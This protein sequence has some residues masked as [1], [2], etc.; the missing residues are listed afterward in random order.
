MRMIEPKVTGAFVDAL[1]LGVIT[2][3]H[4]QLPD[5]GRGRRIHDDE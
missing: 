5:S 2:L 3:G 1:V 4:L